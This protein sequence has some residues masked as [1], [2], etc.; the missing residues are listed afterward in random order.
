MKL[1][2]Q[3]K[4]LYASRWGELCDSLQ[5]VAC[6][7]H[8]AVKPAYPFLLSMVRWENDRPVE[9]WYTDADL[10]VM[11]FGQETN[12][13]TGK[14]DDFGVPPSPVF[15]SDVSMEAVM[16]IYEDFY[17]SY[18]QDGT[19][20]YNGTRY[21]TFHYGLN[22]FT[23][24]LNAAFPDKRTAYVWNNLVK[25]GKSQGAGFCGEEIYSLG[26][27][28]FSVIRKEVDILKPDLLLFLTGTYDGRIRDNWHDAQFSAL[29][30]Y[31]VN[32]AAQ[33]MSSG[34]SVPAYRTNHPSA[35]LPKGEME[36]R[37]RAIIDDFINICKND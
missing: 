10:K 13:W 32:E 28:C 5:S 26:K 25:I 18:Y 17:T 20:S 35:R 22:R 27:N 3:L 24:L 2:E 4:T 36:A 11:V 8:T 12:S 14:N 21:G 33:V 37:Y 23:A 16:G 30:S 15:S 34:L 6:R 1:N 19:F 7:E 29:S 9:K 31:A